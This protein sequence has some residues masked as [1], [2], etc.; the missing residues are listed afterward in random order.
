MV[1]VKA[2]HSVDN[3]FSLYFDYL[4]FKFF[5]VLV[6]RAGFAF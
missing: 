5:P 6:L 1:K 4:K 3:M 2:A